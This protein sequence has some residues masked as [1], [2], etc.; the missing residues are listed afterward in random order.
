MTE[1][2]YDFLDAILSVRCIDAAATTTISLPETDT[3]APYFP[4]TPW[5]FRDTLFA[6]AT[7][8]RLAILAGGVPQRLV[9]YLRR[10]LPVCDIPSLL[11]Q[12]RYTLLEHQFQT[13]ITRNEAQPIRDYKPSYARPKRPTRPSSPL[14]TQAKTQRRKKRKR[15]SKE[16]TWN[17]H[18]EF[19][20]RSKF[21]FTP[22]P[23]AT[24]VRRPNTLRRREETASP[25]NARKRRRYDPGGDGE[26]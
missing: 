16:D 17:Q 25:P 5:A 2:D 20:K 23:Q 8:K 6:S 10:D 26:G 11:R 12:L 19:W 21:F 13:W 1:S 24:V 7:T 14:R 22:T 9:N 18:R 3:D 15:R 4:E